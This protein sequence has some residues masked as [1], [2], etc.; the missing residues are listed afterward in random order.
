MA[1]ADSRLRILPHLSSHFD[2]TTFLG[3]LTFNWALC[4]PLGLRWN[5]AS[6]AEA[7]S[8]I[9]LW[10][11]GRDLP[12]EKL[13]QAQTVLAV[14]APHGTL[15]PPPCRTS[16]WALATVPAMAF[17]QWNAVVRPTSLPHI[18]AG[19]WLNQTQNAAITWS[20]RP[21][22]RAEEGGTIGHAFVA[23]A[24]ACLTAIPIAVGAGIGAQRSRLLRPLGRFAPYP[25][26]ALANVVNT[27][28]MRWDDLQNGVPVMDGSGAVI[29]RS[30]VAG[31]RAVFDTA[32]TRTLVPL[33]NFVGAPIIMACLNRLRSAFRGGSK[34][35]PQSLVLQLAVTTSVLV[36]AIP[37]ASSVSAP[38]GSVAVEDLEP[39]V[40]DEA[41]RRDSNVREVTYLRGF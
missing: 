24:V 41:T 38:I 36:A 27:M 28:M 20:N 12:A 10:R 29:D 23:Y 5:E 3:R 2:M 4:S 9:E 37:V 19:Q 32:L 25:A 6:V 31:Q 40:R 34:A 1:D 17:I 15:L 26:V 11:Q 13:K 18:V 22:N 35:A 30:V 16:G 39:S 21:P 14:S 7:S 8:V 33:A